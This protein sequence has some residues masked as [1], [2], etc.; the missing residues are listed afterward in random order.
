[1]SLL[2]TSIELPQNFRLNDFLVFH[3][4]DS[5]MLAEVVSEH[6]LQKGICWNNMPGLL[7][8]EFTKHR[9]NVQ[10][11]LDQKQ[12]K[13]LAKENLTRLEQQVKHILGL[14]Q[15]VAAFETQFRL[16]PQL[17]HIIQHN[18]GL[19]VPQSAT[20]FEAL[21]WAITG[22]Q[23]SVKAAVSLRRKLILCAG[24]QHSSG[25]WCY[26]DAHRL[27]DIDEATLRENG[28]SQTKA[29]TLINLA[30]EV[31]NGNLPLDTWLHKYWQTGF[32]DANEIY[33]ALIQLRG[34]GPWTVNYA[35]LRGFGWLDGSLHGDIAVRNQLQHLLKLEEKPSEKVASSWLDQFSPWRALTAAHLWNWKYDQNQLA[36]AP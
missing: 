11:H 13:V 21:S 29:S 17:G 16:H 10:L 35:L 36:V 20:T 4:R 34:I 12:K 1:M 33:N 32:L 25:I 24:I 22:Q 9:V 27:A 31:C 6:R 30:Q 28:F 5:Q 23:I 8:L 7:H 3:Q 19:R 18:T 26:P 14:N 15:N 2:N